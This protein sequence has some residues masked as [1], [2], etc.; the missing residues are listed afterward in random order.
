MTMVDVVVSHSR[1]S[2]AGSEWECAAFA[3]K[4]NVVVNFRNLKWCRGFANKSAG[5]PLVGI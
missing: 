2:V 5:L 4:R 3:S 1:L